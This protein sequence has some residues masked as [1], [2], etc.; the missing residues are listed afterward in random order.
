MTEVCPVCGGRGIVAP[1]FHEGVHNPDAT[2]TQRVTCR[3]CG[4]RGV[5]E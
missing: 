2:D 3:T 1:G 5:I 4:G